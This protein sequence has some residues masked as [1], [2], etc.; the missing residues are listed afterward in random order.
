VRKSD[1]NSFIFLDFRRRFLSLLSY[2]FGS[3]SATLALSILQNKVF[4]S[5]KQGIYK[6]KAFTS[7]LHS[8]NIQFTGFMHFL[9][10][11]GA[12]VLY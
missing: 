8:N 1:L 9:N 5:D 2:Q 6:H 7:L 4:A 11:S 12:E 10:T 3:F